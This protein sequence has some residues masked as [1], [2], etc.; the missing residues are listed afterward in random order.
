MA[1]HLST[2]WNKFFRHRTK[3]INERFPGHYRAQVVETNDPL[4]MYRV[5]FR[6]PEMHNSDLPPEDCPWALPAPHL[7]GK[8]AG[9]FNHPCIGDWIWITFEK[10]HPY[11]PIYVGTADPTR[12]QAY[13]LPQISSPTPLPLNPDGKKSNE[14][15]KD[16]KIEYL[17]KDGRPMQTG[18]VDRYGHIELYSSVGYY[19][20]EHERPPPNPDFDPIAEASYSARQSPIV[21]DPDKKYILK[22]TKYGNLILLGDQG[23]YWKKEEDGDKKYGEYTGDT[24]QDFDY[25]HKRWLDIQSLVNENNPTTTK[26]NTDQRRI[27]LVTRYGHKFEMRDV[28]YAQEGPQDNTARKGEVG[29]GRYLSKEKARDQRWIKLRTKSGMLIELND[30][31]TDI[32]E[33]TNVQRT[34]IDE[35]AEEQKQAEAWNDRDSRFIRIVSRHGFKVALDDRGSNSDPNIE[36]PRGNGVLIKGRRSPG[37]G[38]QPVEG[39]QR[40]FYFEFNENDLANN[41]TWGSPMGNIIELN[42]RYQYAMMASSVGR[43][44]SSE[45]KGLEDN[46][47]VGKPSMIEDPEVNSHH[48]KLDHQNEYIRFKTRCGN[49]TAPDNSVG[50]VNGINQGLEARDGNAGDGPWVE[51][52]DSENRGIWFS[53]SKGLSI[54]RGKDGSNMYMWIDD[55]TKKMTLYNA[56]LEG[57]IDLYCAGSIN[58]KSGANINLEAA[59][60]LSLKSTGPLKMQGSSTKLTLQSNL[61]TNGEIRANR[62]RAAI[63]QI[64]SPG[65]L[66]PD[67]TIVPQLPASLFPQDRG[68]TYN[69]PFE[70]VPEEEIKHAN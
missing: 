37:S 62:L 67:T 30:S 16:Y 35:V 69:G 65:G 17:P 1:D 19:P 48:I 11:G 10:Q 66:E 13:T 31:G 53:R 18:Q 3:P 23:F 50:P 9:S 59:G 25:E 54:I 56:N 60:S 33:D 20:Q 6:C 40:G 32:S 58:I 27:M 12:V 49:G 29:E 42:D 7:G 64:P 68:K 45:Y 28:G 57:S 70:A 24:K 21:N 36:L 15:P 41:S 38:G 43:D 4:N 47:F 63:T 14:P 44:F 2:T 55:A 52:V 5:K 39:D 22:A 26:D 51:I 61:Q 34:L 46:E 8:M